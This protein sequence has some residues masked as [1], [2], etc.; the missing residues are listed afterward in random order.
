VVAA[1]LAATNCVLAGRGSSA[2]ATLIK[3]QHEIANATSPF[4]GIG[5]IEFSDL[6]GE[7][8]LV[9]TAPKLY[10]GAITIP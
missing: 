5:I 3:E 4:T 1:V 10:W 8:F 2:R 7:F 6:L 9:K